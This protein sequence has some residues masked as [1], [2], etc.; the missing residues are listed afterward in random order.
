MW[1]LQVCKLQNI[2]NTIAFLYTSN[3]ALI[4]NYKTNIIYKVPTIKH[5]YKLNKISMWSVYWKIENTDERQSTR[6]KYIIN[7]VG[8]KILYGYI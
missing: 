7:L 5:E 3:K 4:L 2:K 8:F 1:S 6:P